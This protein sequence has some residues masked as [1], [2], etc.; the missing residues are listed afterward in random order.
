M[1]P[2]SSRLGDVTYCC[3]LGQFVRSSCVG[4]SQGVDNKVPE[5][6]TITKMM[7]RLIKR[8]SGARQRHGVISLSNE[9]HIVRAFRPCIVLFFKQGLAAFFD[10]LSPCTL[11]GL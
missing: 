3:S 11:H 1:L 4:L 5:N 10:S 8:L 7:Q 6:Y 2:R 9:F